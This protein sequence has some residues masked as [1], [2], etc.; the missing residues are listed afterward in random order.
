MDIKSKGITW[1][2]NFYQ[3]IETICLEVDN[4]VTNQDT[5]KY[6]ENQVQT[7]GGSLKKF[8]SSVV[9]DL[10]PPSADPVK[11][12]AEAESL[13]RKAAVGP[14]AK[15]MIGVVNFPLDAAI[16]QSHVDFSANDPFKNHLDHAMGGLQLVDQ[17]VAPDPEDSLEK[18]E[19]ELTSGLTDDILTEGDSDSSTENNSIKEK[20]LAYNVVDLISPDEKSSFEALSF[21]E[22][23]DC[24]TESACGALAKDS[25]STS[26][27][28]DEF[29]SA[30]KLGNVCDNF[31]TIY[32]SSDCEEEIAEMGL[33]SSNT[34]LLIE[35]CTLFENSH[36]NI[37]RRAVSYY[38][39]VDVAGCVSE[40][41]KV[42][43]CVTSAP[44]IPSTINLA[45]K[46]LISSN[47]ELSLK[48]NGPLDDSYDDL[49]DADMETIQLGDQMKLEHSL[50]FAEDSELYAVSRRTQ[51]LRSYKKKIQDAFSSK[52]RLAKEYGKIAIWY[53]DIDI[54]ST[55]NALPT[56][57]ISLGS[58][59]FGTHH[60]CDSEW[61]LL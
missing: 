53:G 27:H 51:R 36:L 7:A 31:A 46:E 59:N 20:S 40:S 4:I 35:S 57:T 44:I 56:T 54:G 50:V 60:I 12:E 32:G 58:D 11:L 28:G 6:V 34:P 43:R 14:D 21:S 52:K 5:I 19:F 61:E 3:K 15:L 13:K 9:Q 1:V 49:N 48:S 25:P 24:N 23:V 26:V 30:P 47:S 41:P 33:V 55:Q 18:T 22:Y 2:G 29:Q 16:K 42:L 8:C 17:I 39:P 10:L 38:N 37:P 45:K